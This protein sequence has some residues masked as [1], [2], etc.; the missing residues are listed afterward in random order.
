MG[1]FN[2]NE[3]DFINNNIFKFEDR[4]NSQVTRFTD[5]SASYVTYFNIIQ[6]ESMVDLGFSNIEH[7]LGPESPLRFSEIKDFPVYG[8][9]PIQLRLED[10]EA[11]LQTEYEGEL[12]ILPNT[13]KPTPNDF[14]ILS[15]V[16]KDFI[17]MI[18]SVDYDTIKSNNYYKCEFKVKYIHS[19]ELER[20][21]KQVSEEYTCVNTNIG[22]QDKSIIENDIL[23]ALKQLQF[24]YTDI[25]KRYVLYFF[26]D[27][28]NSFIYTNKAGFRIYDRYL[29][30]FLQKNSLFNNRNDHLT[31]MVNNEDE[32]DDFLFEYDK[33]IYHMM[34]LK[35]PD[36]IKR[37]AFSIT[38]IENMYS[39]FKYY[40]DKDVVSVRFK[41]GEI[42]YIHE[43]FTTAL[44]T[45]KFDNPPCTH[46]PPLVPECD[47]CRV[48]NNQT[49]R[50]TITDK[51]VHDECPNK[52]LNE[53]DK[54]I[55]NY[56]HDKYSSPLEINIEE[57]NKL[58]FFEYS[59]ENFTK[60]P[61][62]LFSLRKIY[63][64]FINVK[65]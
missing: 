52:P 27:K 18:T 1:G 3:Q 31:I 24:I 16:G 63:D 19:E 50:I 40:G 65:P 54:V 48:L 64:R 38:N 10:G 61:L 7:L 20:I 14:F 25:A 43:P 32:T 9:D 22:T 62:F 2:F 51:F 34:E 33:S 28:Y 41:H 15:Y 35:R 55:I 53:I 17:F 30:S 59:W 45:G 26:K 39:V 49:E 13:I 6:N 36:L 21:R 4:L 44:H 23:N 42:C 57:L 8:I 47:Y 5:K 58:L 46:K 37:Y 12:Y 60:I 11:G 56:M 29:S